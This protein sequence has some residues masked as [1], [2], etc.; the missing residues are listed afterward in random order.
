[1]SMASVDMSTD[2]LRRV[3]LRVMS[4]GTRRKAVPVKREGAYQAQ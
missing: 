2:I 1:M 4:S 3:G